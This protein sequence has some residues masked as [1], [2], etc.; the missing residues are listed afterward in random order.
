MRTSRNREVFLCPDQ[1]HLLPQISKIGRK[2]LYYFFTIL[3]YFNTIIVVL[4]T[5]V[6][7]S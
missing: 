2:S 5:Y 3:Y 6:L 1:Y 4:T 7:M